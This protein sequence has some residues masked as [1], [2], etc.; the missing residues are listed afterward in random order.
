MSIYLESSFTKA[1]LLNVNWC[2]VL[3]N[4]EDKVMINKD[5]DRS[6]YL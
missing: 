5:K 2:F 3:S 4:D 6:D 1:Q